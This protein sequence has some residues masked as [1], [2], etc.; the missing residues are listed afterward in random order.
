MS[1]CLPPGEQFEGSAVIVSGPRAKYA[2]DVHLRQA[3]TWDPF[4][5]CLHLDISSSNKI[6]RN[7]KRL[8]ITACV[9]RWLKLWTKRYKKAKTQLPLLRFQEQK[10]G[11]MHDA[12]TEHHKG[13]GQ[14]TQTPSGPHRSTPPLTPLKEPARPPQRMSKGTCD[15]FS[16]PPAAA[17]VSTKA[18]PEFLVWPLTNFYWLKCPR[19]IDFTRIPNIKKP[20]KARTDTN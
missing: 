11:A 1:S 10:Q 20:L 17:P 16:L 7:Y 5:Q 18:L 15:L 12:C 14:T 2:G 19:T 8:K 4:L 9:G 6:Q 3:G 13:G